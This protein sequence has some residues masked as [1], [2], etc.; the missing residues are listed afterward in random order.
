MIRI[1]QIWLAVDPLGMHSGMD[2][3]LARVVEVF[4]AS[5]PHH[6]YVLPTVGVRG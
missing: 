6:A 1:E 4:G 2:W 3:L 5:Q